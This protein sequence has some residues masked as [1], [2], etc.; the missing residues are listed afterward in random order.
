MHVC[1]GNYLG[2][3][4]ATHPQPPRIIRVASGLDTSRGVVRPSLRHTSS[5]NMRARAADTAKC[6]EPTRHPPHPDV[7]CVHTLPPPLA[8]FEQRCAR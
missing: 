7:W 5:G 6:D 1:V 3:E 4:P 8:I 2:V